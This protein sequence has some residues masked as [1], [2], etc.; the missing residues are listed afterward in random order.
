MRIS[1][2]HTHIPSLEPPSP[3]GTPSRSSQTRLPG[4][5]GGLRSCPPDSDGVHMS[6]PPSPSV[7]LGPSPAAS[8]VHSLH[9]CLHSF[10][11][12]TFIN[13]SFSGFHIYALKVTSHCDPHMPRFDVTVPWGSGVQQ[14]PVFLTVPRVS[15]GA[16]PA[17]LKFCG[18][19]CLFF[20]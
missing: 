4:L 16:G 5:Q 11:A 10:L 13:T 3:P 15:G 18:F 12:N 19:F 17:G 7:A 8:T 2:N 20:F 14:L 9:L 1:R 6:M